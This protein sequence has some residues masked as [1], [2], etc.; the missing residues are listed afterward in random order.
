MQLKIVIRENCFSRHRDLSGLLSDFFPLAVGSFRHRP[1]LPSV[2]ASSP[3]WCFFFMGLIFLPDSPKR[4]P[5]NKVPVLRMY[6][7]G[8]VFQ[9]T[10]THRAACSQTSAVQHAVMWGATCSRIRS[11]SRCCCR[12]PSAGKTRRP[13]STSCGTAH[14][15]CRSSGSTP[16]SAYR[17]RRPAPASVRYG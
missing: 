11:H 8:L 2:Y 12:H 7:A 15:D 16:C 14:R 10:N 6:S 5:K 4:F 3:T 13:E 17:N 9:G 1:C